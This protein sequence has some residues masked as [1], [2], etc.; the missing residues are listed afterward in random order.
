VKKQ[1]PKL[2]C[3]I[4]LTST[5]NLETISKKKDRPDKQWDF[6]DGWEPHKVSIFQKVY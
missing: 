1:L 5:T 6:P 4:G 3:K 2:I